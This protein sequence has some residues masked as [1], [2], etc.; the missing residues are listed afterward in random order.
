LDSV[1]RHTDWEVEGLDV[2]AFAAGFARRRYGLNVQCTTLEQAQYPDDRFDFVVQ[3]DV[4]EHVLRPR[5]HLRETHRIMRPGGTLWLIT[6]N[7][8]ANLRPLRDLAASPR[9]SGTGAVPLLDQGHL[10][11]FS[12]ENLVRIASESGFT[13][14]RFRH[15]GLRRGL[16]ALGVLPRKRR[17][18]RTAPGGRTRRDLRHDGAG[19]AAGGPDGDRLYER[20]SAEVDRAR[21]SL[22]CWPPYMHFRRAARA[23]GSL[24][25]PFALGHDFELFLKKT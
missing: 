15:I 10:S 11:F 3:K 12:R 13:C 23:L 20:M 7:G 25:G 14:D 22:R 8:E 19:P 21:T 18:Q 1:K 17:A 6:P 4:L 9:C 24:P 16:R 5:D 2:A